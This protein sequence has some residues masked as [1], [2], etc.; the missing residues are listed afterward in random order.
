[1]SDE[2]NVQSENGAKPDSGVGTLSS[3][4]RT[5]PVING[6]AAEVPASAAP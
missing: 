6:E 2:H 4:A 1:M 5:A 3:R